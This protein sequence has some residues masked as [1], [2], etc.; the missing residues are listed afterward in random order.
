[1]CMSV[2]KPQN[3]KREIQQHVDE[4]RDIKN[5]ERDIEYENLY[6]HHNHFRV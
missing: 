5:V 1:M 4:V 6:F 2:K 3:F